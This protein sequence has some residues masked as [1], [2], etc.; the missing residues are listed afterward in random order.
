MIKFSTGVE[1][2]HDQF[3]SGHVFGGVFI[4]GNTSTVI[5]NRDTIIFVNGYPY[6]STV[7]R[8][9]FIDTVIN[10]FPYEVVKTLLSGIAYVHGRSFPY[11]LQTIQYLNLLCT[12]IT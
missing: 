2:G 4:Y 9:C 11:C 12:V 8:K 1:G 6:T 5:L 7:T 10:N 3:Q